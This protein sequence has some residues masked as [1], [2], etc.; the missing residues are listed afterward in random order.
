LKEFIVN[1]KERPPAGHTVRGLGERKEAPFFS[2]GAIRDKCSLQWRL[3][4]DCFESL[5]P[6]PV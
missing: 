6:L 5:T 3:Q 4:E 2:P 1:I